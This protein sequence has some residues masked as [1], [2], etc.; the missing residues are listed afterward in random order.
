M[1]VPQNVLLNKN[2]NPK[3]CFTI[4]FDKQRN[5]FAIVSAVLKMKHKDMSVVTR[6]RVVRGELEFLTVTR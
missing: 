5:L 4:N 1:F 3:T 6:Q 2:V